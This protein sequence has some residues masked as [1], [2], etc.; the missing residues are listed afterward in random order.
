M[1]TLHRRAALSRPA[2]AVLV[3][4]LAALI[5]ACGGGGGGSSGGSVTPPATSCTATARKQWTLDVMREWYLYPELLPATV[6]LDLYAGPQELIDALTATARAQGKDRYFSYLT[7]IVEENA[8]Y[9]SGSTA[10]FGIR[11][12]YDTVNRKLFVMESFEGAP[13]LNAGIDRGDEIVS[14]GTSAADDRLVSDLYASG[15]SAA[16]ADALGPSTAGVSRYLE[17]SRNAVTRGVT[18]TKTD[19]SLTPV[20]SRYGAR[21]IDDG[22][23][24]VGYLNLRTFISTADARLREEFLKFRNAGIS[25]FIIDLRY[26]GG[27]LVS[28]G[29][30]MGDLLGGNRSSGQI[31]SQITYRPEKS[32]NN[33]TKYFAAQPEAVSPVKLAFVTTGAT[34]SASELVINGFI[35]YFTSNLALVGANTYGKP[36]GQVAFDRSACDDRLRVIAFSTRNA[37]GSD[38]YFNGLASTVGASCAAGDDITHAMGDALEGSTRQALD[39]LAGRACTAITADAAAGLAKPGL[40]ELAEE[41]LMPARP[42]PAQRQVP[43][44]F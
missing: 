14:I 29:Q 35:P 10:G 7:S 31:F 17:V 11:L 18:L 28:I 1:N 16:V 26:N 40:P 36:V 15:G 44:L 12:R 13:A 22:G 19:Y 8:Y 37:A 27:G 2:R 5:T 43:G 20:S 3:T 32:S 21:I 23:R 24:R 33:S 6:N 9:A 25:E 42:T 38:N 41:L 34:A 30:L 39:F 4:A